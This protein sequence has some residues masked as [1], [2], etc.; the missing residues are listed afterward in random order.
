MAE[1]S[2]PPRDL[3]RRALFLRGMM[4]A[5]PFNLAVI[6]FS[7]LFGVVAVE[8]G[9][10]IAQIMGMAVVVIAGAAQLTAIQLMQENAPTVMVIVAACAVNLRMAMYSASLAP[11]LSHGPLKWRLVLSYF[12][13]DHVYAMTIAEYPK[14]PE[15]SFHDKAVYYM[16]L[17]LGVLP[18]WYLFSYIGAVIGSQIPES[19]AL[20]FA[21]PIMFTALAAPLI[22]GAANIAAALTAVVVALLAA[23]LPYSF[24]MVVGAV[25][26]ISVGVA[27]ETWRA[28]RRADHD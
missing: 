28:T 20:D 24:G 22:R 19:F 12:L 27:V 26:G 3:N 18:S 25:A 21:G 15:W 6:P 17:S 5:A 14:R 8:A 9:F 2:L 13:V 4:E 16:G 1:L 11:H 23:D 10:D 7:L